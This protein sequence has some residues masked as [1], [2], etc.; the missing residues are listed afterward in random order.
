MTCDFGDKRALHATECHREPFENRCP[1]DPLRERRSRTKYPSQVSAM[2][3]SLVRTEQE[4]YPAWPSIEKGLEAK[5]ELER[6]QKY[7]EE[8]LLPMSLGSGERKVSELGV[9]QTTKF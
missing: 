3:R 9:R 1:Q 7:F 4:H 2:L 8:Q 6:C 5:C